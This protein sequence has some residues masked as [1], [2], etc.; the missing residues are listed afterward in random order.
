MSNS[1]FASTV[2]EVLLESSAYEMKQGLLRLES[3]ASVITSTLFDRI[4]RTVTAI[5]NSFP[6]QGG[7]VLIGVA[8]SDSDAD[9]VYEIYGVSPIIY[10]TLRIVGVEREADAMGVS[11]DEYWDAVI[12]KI[13]MSSKLDSSYAKRVAKSARVA[14]HEGRKMLVIDAPT[15]RDPVA[16][17][18]K[19]FERIGTS[20]EEVKDLI[21][22]GRG[23][24]L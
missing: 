16:F 17:D 15:T 1:E 7:H 21:A 23:F 5:S 12:R 9:R 22:F 20:T 8:D 18:G 2:S 14:V 3:G 10:R 13:S 4:L 24:D 6:K 19:Y 11:F